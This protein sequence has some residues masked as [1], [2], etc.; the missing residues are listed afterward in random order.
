MFVGSRRG[1]G[2]GG[3]L[4]RTS[5]DVERVNYRTVLVAIQRQHS[6]RL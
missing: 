1:Q 6:K 2:E 4:R 5:E 3:G